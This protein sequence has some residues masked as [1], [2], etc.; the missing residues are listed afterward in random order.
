[1]SFGESLI[2]KINRILGHPTEEII[3]KE[4][5]PHEKIIIFDESGNGYWVRPGEPL[6]PP[7]YIR[8]SDNSIK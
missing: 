8:H 2:G 7:N 3:I 5:N 1:M 4:G 6:C